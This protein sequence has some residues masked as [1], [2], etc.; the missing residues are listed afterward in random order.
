MNMKR[1]EGR[2]FAEGGCLFMVLST[3]ETSGTAQ[4][5][6]RMDGQQLVLEMPLVEVSR[7]VASSNGLIL[8]NLN[9]PESRKRLSETDEGWC[10]TTREGT[11]GPFETREEAARELGRYVLSRQT[12]TADE[13]ARAAKGKRRGSPNRRTSDKPEP[14]RAAG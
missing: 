11:E 12:D 8:D 14:L 13:G 3:D 7:R 10:F 2:L 4:V 5:S 1:F 9:S 6:C